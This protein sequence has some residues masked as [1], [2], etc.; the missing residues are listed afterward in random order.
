MSGSLPGEPSLAPGR[1]NT[2]IFWVPMT[3][4]DDPIAAASLTS[5]FLEKALNSRAL[6]SISPYAG[7]LSEM[8]DQVKTGDH[9][10]SREFM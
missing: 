1:A 2:A 10:P 9:W 7:M 6:D 5:R 4:A 3:D 8:P